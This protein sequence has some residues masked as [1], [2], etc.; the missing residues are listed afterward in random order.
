MARLAPILFV[1]AALIVGAILLFGGDK[2][3][4]DDFDY[5]ED[6]WVEG[7]GPELR[8]SDAP[9]TGTRKKSPS[10]TNT[11]DEQGP[12]RGR[13]KFITGVVLDAASGKP[14]AGATLQAEHAA[15][16][17]PRLAFTV[18]QGARIP[19]SAYD[20]SSGPI[21]PMPLMGSVRTG[22]DG[23]FTWWVGD[24]RTLADPCDVTAS[25]PGYVTTMACK[26]S[27]GDDITIR[28]EKAVTLTVEVT[29]PHG[30][31]IEAAMLMVR[32]GPKTRPIPGTAGAGTTDEN[33][34]G[35]VPGLAPARLDPE[36]DERTSVVL[37]VDHPDWM[38]YAS[39]PFDP[40]TTKQMQVKLQPALK[41]SLKIR[42]D[43]GSAVAN[44]ILTWTTDGEPPATHGDLLTVSPNGPEGEPTSE[45]VSE[46]V[47]IPCAHRNVLLQVKADGFTEWRQKEPLPADGGTREVIAILTRDTGLTSLTLRYEN[48]SGELVPYTQLGSATP[49]LTRLDNESIGSVAIEQGQALV[50][51]S[52]P[53]G[54]YRVTKRS[55]SYAP[56][57][58]DVEIR[59]G[60]PT[61]KTLKLEPP[62]KLRVRFT[63]NAPYTVEFRLVQGRYVVPGFRLKEDGTLDEAQGGT[64]TGR[65]ALFTGLPAGRVTLEVTSPGLVAPPTALNLAL[66]ETTEVEIEV[67]A[68]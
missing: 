6:N 63:S 53:P 7:K 48:A 39:E 2:E 61:E 34:R 17:C 56:A 5:S 25:A 26:P 18:L 24:V 4:D 32:P 55:P 19:S 38:P 58:I 57:T 21:G 13:A 29:D 52:L 45:V 60:E 66:G 65:G 67:R 36:T 49:E 64:E 31:P 27:V 16:V 41:L 46:P 40:G 37:H 15:G 44:P 23:R 12:P 9:R 8:T 28:L 33:G 1:L 62:A 68:R 14:I 50:I 47:R 59:A 54:S 11:P 42:S 10:T 30:R 3:Q 20:G 51:K 22:E 43:D 35:M